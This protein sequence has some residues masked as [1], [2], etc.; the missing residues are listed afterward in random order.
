MK[1]T[2]PFTIVYED[3]HI[4]A[5]NKASGIAICAD[6]WDHSAERLDKILAAHLNREKVFVV[7]RVDR[8]TSGLVIFAKNDES[9][10]KLSMAF[11]N[12]QIKKRYIAVV[13]GRPHW[14]ETIC[15]LPLVPD[16][17]KQH[18]TIIDKY[19]GKESLT[20]FRLLCNAGNYS[21]VEAVP[22]TGRTHQIRVH[23]ASLGHSVVCD[24]FYGNAKP[25]FLSAIKPG[26]RGD[27]LEERPILARLGLHAEEL[28]LPYGEKGSMALKAPL[29]RDM[30]A[31]VKQMEK[32]S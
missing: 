12:R 31:L 14:K 22:E 21:I 9:H 10:R 17:N 8:D 1:Q 19:Q 30:A 4:V 13:R 25:V 2:T 16:G 23:L 27:K 20:K 26:W 11:E 6:R 7:H 3:E 32:C 5:V 29:P 15:D 18:L 28:I 24:A